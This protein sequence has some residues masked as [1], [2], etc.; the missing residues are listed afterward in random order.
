MAFILSTADTLQLT[1]EQHKLLNNAMSLSTDFVIKDYA[2]ELYCSYSGWTIS[3]YSGAIVVDGVL[4]INTITTNMIYGTHSSSGTAMVIAKVDLST[5]TFTVELKQGTTLTQNNLISNPTGTREVELYR[6]TYTTSAITSFTDKRVITTSQE[7][8]DAIR[9]RT[10]QY[11]TSNTSA[12]T[13]AKVATL[14][15]FVLYTGARITV[16]FTYS[17]T[18]SSPTL[19]INGTGAKTINP[20]I[21]WTAGE[22]VDFVY[23]GTN[24]V[25][26]N[27]TNFS[28]FKFKEYSANIT[29]GANSTTVT[30]MGALS[31]PSG[32]TYIG[33]IP[34]QNGVGD[35]WSV[36]YGV[37]DSNIV[38]YAKSYYGSSLSR[39]IKC[40]AMFV[41]TDY[42]TLNSI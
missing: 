40:M 33:C 11:A 24:Y 26:V 35:Q 31:T 16:K 8:V 2:N 39:G 25:P 21:Q 14:S 5:K 23:D 42:L 4:C 7:V 29:V 19:N 22:T 30:T 18:A 34:K 17:N 32:Y 3:V 9:K 6:F 37:Y 38:A 13:T 27:N 20:A 1:G 36:T 10:V 41:K 12:S 15:D 28:L